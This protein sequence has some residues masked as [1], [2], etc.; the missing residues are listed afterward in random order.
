MIRWRHYNYFVR[1]LQTRESVLEKPGQLSQSSVLQ[2][3]L[4]GV[5]T[6]VR[7]ASQQMRHQE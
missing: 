1:I 2:L 4:G 3:E 5:C 6:C 7:F